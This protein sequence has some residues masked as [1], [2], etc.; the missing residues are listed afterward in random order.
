MQRWLHWR[1]AT[2]WIAWKQPTYA[3]P[4]GDEIDILLELAG[5]FPD[6]YGIQWRQHGALRAT[7]PEAQSDPSL[8]R[9]ALFM[10]NLTTG[11]ARSEGDIYIEVAYRFYASDHEI[12]AD[13]AAPTMCWCDTLDGVSTSCLGRL[14]F[15]NYEF[16]LNVAYNNAACTD[17]VD[18]KRVEEFKRAMQTADRLIGFY[19]EPL[20]RKPHWL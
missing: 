19:L 20:R 3:P 15:D 10:H 18:P 4:L 9:G 11:A 16:S 13:E 17:P 14:A 12:D 8:L 6:N 1:S 2:L 5:V 7:D